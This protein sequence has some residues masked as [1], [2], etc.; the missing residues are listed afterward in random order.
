MQGWIKLHRKLV[1]WEWYTDSQAVHLFIHLVIHANFEDKKWRGILV[2]RG[3]FITGR[4]ELSAA[5][6]ISEQSIRTNITRLKS[7]NEITSTSTSKY[8]IYTIVNYDK[9]QGLDDK[10]TST[11]TSQLTNDQPA[12]NQQLTTTKNEKNINNEKKEVITPPKKYSDEFEEF[13]QAYPKNGASKADAYKSFNKAIKTGVSQNELINATRSYF[14]YCQAT[15]KTT[16]YTAHA[17][18]WLNQERWTIDYRELYRSEKRGSQ[19]SNGEG[20][21]NQLQITQ[22][23]AEA[24]IAD[25]LNR[26][27]S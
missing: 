5:T 27:S 1:D 11:S 20:F 9:F 6:G 3:Q 7:T 15:N 14:S 4:H 12:T 16:E 13:W 26:A 24:L 25:R 19:Q 10:P 22:T 21:A 17:T 2:K 23:I 18:T 8:T